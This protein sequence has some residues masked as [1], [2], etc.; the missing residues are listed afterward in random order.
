MTAERHVVDFG[1]QIHNAIGLVRTGQYIAAAFAVGRFARVNESHV[2]CVLTELERKH[3]H[4]AIVALE[5]IQ[6]IYCPAPRPRLRL[7]GRC[8]DDCVT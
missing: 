4:N 7:I 1:Q 2:S 6:S 8:D 5:L 3:A